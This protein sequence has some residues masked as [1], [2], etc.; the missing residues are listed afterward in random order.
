[1]FS[2]TSEG[3]GPKVNAPVSELLPETGT[4]GPLLLADVGKPLGGPG[5]QMTWERLMLLWRGL[6]SF[7]SF[8]SGRPHQTNEEERARAVRAPLM[9]VQSSQPQ[10]NGLSCSHSIY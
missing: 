7:S 2:I 9:G 4:G 8:G 6:L 5:W 10:M 1:M 3:S